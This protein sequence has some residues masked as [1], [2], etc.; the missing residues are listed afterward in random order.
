MTRAARRWQLW[1]SLAACFVFLIGC[2]EE[3]VVVPTPTPLSAELQLGVKVFSD[4]CA[5]CHATTP[6]TVIRGPSMHQLVA[7]AGERVDGQDARTYIYSSIMRPSDYV[8]DGY[9][10]VM[11]S[12][13]AKTMTGEELDAV[14]AY[15]L[16]FE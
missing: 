11:P 3:E 1:L 8:V 4:N 9:E 2:G 16:T 6:D 5:I 12:T 15:L 14:V 13:L 10:D 7:R